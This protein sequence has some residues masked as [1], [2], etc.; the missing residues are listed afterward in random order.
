MPAGMLVTAAALGVAVVAG[1]VAMAIA[2]RHWKVAT[3][4]LSER[5]MGSARGSPEHL[6]DGLDALPIPVQRYFRT[7]LK[8]GQRLPV[9]A[10]LTQAGTFRTDLMAA[11]SAGLAPVRGES[12]YDLATSRV[13]LGRQHRD[14]AS[15]PRSG[16]ATPTCTAMP[17]CSARCAEPSGSLTL[18]TMLPCARVPCSATWPKRCGSRPRFCRANRCSGP[19]WTRATH[20]PRSMTAKRSLRSPV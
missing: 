17:Q 4:D 3:V 8:A 13:R 9:A 5:L 6:R 12:G 10:R 20:G 2:A 7:V 1:V 14:G 15:C 18:A 11:P 16:S 19:P